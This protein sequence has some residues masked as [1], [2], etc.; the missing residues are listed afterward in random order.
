M[1]R[2]FENHHNFH[3]HMQLPPKDSSPLLFWGDIST[4][5]Q[6][7]LRLFLCFKTFINGT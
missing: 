2:L 5:T 3:Q 7:G 4:T 6:K 1:Q